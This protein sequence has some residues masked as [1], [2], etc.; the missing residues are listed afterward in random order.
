MDC[1]PKRDRMTWWG[2]YVSEG[3]VVP[4]DLLV[5]VPDYYIG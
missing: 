5:E 3:D 1:T 2:Y 4:T